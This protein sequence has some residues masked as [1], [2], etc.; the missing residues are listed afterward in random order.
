MTNTARLDRL[1]A[2]LEGLAP[3]ITVRHAGDVLTAAKYASEDVH[4]LRLLLITRGKTW[5]RLGNKER[6]SFAA[7][8]IAVLRG[9]CSY[10]L[11]PC[12]GASAPGVMCV[13]ARFNGPAGAVLLE[14]F[15]CP[16]LMPLN[17]SE[18][19]LD[20]VVQLI[21][22]EVAQPRCG[23]PALLA[24]AGD[25]LFIGLLRHLIAYPRT[26]FGLLNGLSDHRIARALVAIHGAPHMSWTLDTLA[27]EAGMS[28]TAFAILF[29]EAM[30]RTPGS[31]LAQLRLSIA[32]RAVDNGYGLKRAARESG[33]ASTTAL[34][35]ALARLPA[36]GP[37]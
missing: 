2:L 10:S 5:I 26:A 36:D 1:S 17:E 29:R 20:L 9:D 19:E 16:L 28:R 3:Q 4:F 34:S 35:R 11:V 27:Q 30:N 24:R 6:Q 33:Y 32:R 25:I 8:A 15:A 18:P 14:A 21:A 37:V 22:F 13:E 23:Q 12:K 31:Y 7:P